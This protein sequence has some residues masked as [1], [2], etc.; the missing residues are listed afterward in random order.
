MII[1]FPLFTGLQMYEYFFLFKHLLH[2]FSTDYFVPAHYTKF[3]LFS[4]Y[5]LQSF[6]VEINSLYLL[7][8]PAFSLRS[9]AEYPFGSRSRNCGRTANYRLDTLSKKPSFKK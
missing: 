3:S 5:I 9:I 2:Y 7:P 6:S 8:I 4:F 1:K